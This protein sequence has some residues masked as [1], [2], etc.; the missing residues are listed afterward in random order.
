MNTTRR[1]LLALAAAWAAP[2]PLAH[3]QTATRMRRVGVLLYLAGDDP[4][5]KS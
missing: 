4:E 3:A 5:A 1:D 2:W